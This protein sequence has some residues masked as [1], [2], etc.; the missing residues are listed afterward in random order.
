MDPHFKL[1]YLVGSQS[2][3]SLSLLSHF[4]AMDRYKQLL[5]SCSAPIYHST[6]SLSL[7]MARAKVDFGQFWLVAQFVK[8]SL[9][10]RSLGSFGSDETVLALKGKHTPPVQ[11][12]LWARQRFVKLPGQVVGRGS[13]EKGS[14]GFMLCK[15]LGGRLNSGCTKP[16][17]WNSVPRPTHWRLSSAA[18]KPL[19]D[20]G[21]C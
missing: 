1:R 16:R 7:I 6:H 3:S 21:I 10:P 11:R 15:V 13:T 20:V 9:I 4:L 17:Y 14:R 8:G 5:A 2:G 18:P 19:Y 12:L